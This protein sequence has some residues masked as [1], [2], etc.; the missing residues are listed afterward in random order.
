MG[1]AITAAI[2]LTVS[3][4]LNFM[5][6]QHEEIERLER[7]HAERKQTLVAALATVELLGND[8][9]ECRNGR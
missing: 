1:A 2:V 7:N 4:A 6:Y 8:L 9:E 5:V 3:I